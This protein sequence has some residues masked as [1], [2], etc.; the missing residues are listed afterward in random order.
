[1]GFLNKWF[2]GGQVEKQGA[3]GAIDGGHN[4]QKSTVLAATDAA[5]VTP[6]NADFSSVRTAPVVTKPR[7]MNRADA[8]AL[9]A[10]AKEKREM[11]D[12]TEEAYSAL[13]SL[14]TSDARVSNAHRKYQAKQAKKEVEKLEGNAN[15]AKELHKL[16]PKYAELS[17]GVDAAENAATQEI[18]AIK[19]AYGVTV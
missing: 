14:E 12:A 17:Q 8:Q 11:A 18:A 2:G 7:Y 3:G 6:T 1:M 5:V 15:L 19:N 10:L 13:G 4:L 9:K 16:R